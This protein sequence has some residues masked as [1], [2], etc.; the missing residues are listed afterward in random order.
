[1]LL[2]DLIIEV[3]EKINL[4][5]KL[6][7]SEKQ[8]H[9]SKQLLIAMNYVLCTPGKRVRPFLVLQCAKLVGCNEEVAIIL[10]VAIE[11]IHTYSL[12]HDD[13]PA[14]DDDD[15][16]RGL[17]SCHKK[18]GEGMAILVGDGLLT[19][20]FEVLVGI[21]KH[22]EAEKV[23]ELILSISQASGYQG[24]VGGQAI[25]LYIKD[26]S[27]DLKSNSYLIEEMQTM[28]TA[29]LFIAACESPAIIVG[30]NASRINLAGYGKALGLLFQLTD[31]I[32][33]K[34]LPS[35]SNQYELADK[36]VN[37]AKSHLSSFGKSPDVEV[38]EELIHL[39]RYREH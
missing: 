2:K 4:A 25:D 18:F 3:E 38:L 7:L 37:T 30:D 16:R 6:L 31:D 10:A 26:N 32:I 34:E 28:K 1:M 5:L 13:L 11:L 9:S 12:V 27:K 39:I 17:P 15:Y 20:A 36:L 21:R 19:L 33:D 23:L 22:V 24:M 29:S 35:S 8:E 14:M